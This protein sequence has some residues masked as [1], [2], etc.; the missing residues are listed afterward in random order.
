MADDATSPRSPSLRRRFA[1]WFGLLFVLGAV[2][3]RLA[4]YQATVATLDRDL[5]ELL[6]SRLGM[7]RVLDRFEPRLSLGDQFDADHRLP[8]ERKAEA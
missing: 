3:T 1:L 6:W 4:Y 8:I 7:V 5:D 2:L